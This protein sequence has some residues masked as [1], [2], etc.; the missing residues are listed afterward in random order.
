MF[1]IAP[2]GHAKPAVDVAVEGTAVIEII[3]DPSPS[4]PKA[5]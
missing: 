5:P 4:S 1:W 2:D 3:E